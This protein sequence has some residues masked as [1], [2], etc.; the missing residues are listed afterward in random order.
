MADLSLV[1]KNN[2]DLEEREQAELEAQIREFYFQN[3]PPTLPKLVDVSIE[4]T[5]RGATLFR[6]RETFIS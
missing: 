1:V 3:E 2:F 6:T 5:I 4:A